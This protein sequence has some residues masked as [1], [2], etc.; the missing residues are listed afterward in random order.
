MAESKRSE[1]LSVSDAAK[2]RLSPSSHSQSRRRLSVS[3]SS[4][5]PRSSIPQQEQHNSGIM[6]L[7]DQCQNSRLQPGEGRRAMPN[8]TSRHC[9][10]RRMCAMDCCWMNSSTWPLSPKTT[11]SSRNPNNNM[12]GCGTA[13]QAW[14][15][16]PPISS[17]QLV[18][19]P[20]Q[21]WFHNLLSAMN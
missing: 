5:L 17:F 3:S 21:V 19:L 1:L 9:T 13:F 4:N 15:C 18:D 11:S 12:H 10:Y 20:Q 16:T 14:G 8:F 7:S 6:A 2:Q